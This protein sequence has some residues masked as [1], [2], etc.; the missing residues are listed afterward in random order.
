[1]CSFP[2]L[3]FYVIS[4]P[5]AFLSPSLVFSRFC[6]SISIMLSLSL[7]VSVS[8]HLVLS[9]TLHLHLVSRRRTIARLR[10]GVRRRRRNTSAHYRRRYTEITLLGSLQD[11]SFAC[12]LRRSRCIWQTFSERSHLCRCTYLPTLFSNAMRLHPAGIDKR[13]CK[14]TKFFFLSVKACRAAH[15]L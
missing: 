8:L 7:S 4:L 9:P 14:V 15:W 13:I 2:V 10:Q 3:H 6:P 11:L 12:Y 1:M 5:H